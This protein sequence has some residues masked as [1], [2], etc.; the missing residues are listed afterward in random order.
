MRLAF[1]LAIVSLMNAYNLLAQDNSDHVHSSNSSKIVAPCISDMEYAI[2]E[3]R[4]NENRKK[5][6]FEKANIKKTRTTSLS[7][8]LKAANGLNDC[9]Y[10]HISAYVDHNVAV[11]TIQ[12]YNCGT[13]T[14]DGHRGTDISIWPFNFHK[15]DNNQVE[16]IAAAPG[17]ILDKHDGEFDRNC[18]ANNLTANYVIIQHLDGSQILYWHMKKNSIT[19][20]A[21]GQSVVTGEKLG[22]VGSS[23]SSSGPH[24][25]FEVWA[26]NAV[27]TRVDPFSGACNM[28]NA[29]SWWANQKP[30]KET[31]I[32]RA[33]V[34]T[35]DAVIPPC[36]TT[37]TL[38]ES[39]SYT[40]PFQGAGLPPGYAKFYI[41]IKDEINGL[42]GN[43]SILNPDNTTYLSWGYNSV[44]D[45]KIRMW[46]WSKVLPVAPGT[47]TFKA[48]YNGI[49]CSTTFDI[50]L[51]AGIN[52]VD[53]QKQILVYPIPNNG[54]FVVD[55]NSNEVQ[56][57]DILSIDGKLMKHVQLI[58]Q[59]T[60]I[61]LNVSKG[62]YFYQIRNANQVV[63]SGKM[64]VE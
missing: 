44:A 12:D 52:L 36:P 8:P 17:I 61:D 21:I 54:T 51:P 5:I 29:T 7:W 13:I 2:I 28:L 23:G 37:E 24:L 48:E 58:D 34:H 40:I 39:T 50:V 3:N 20:K 33:T 46:G 41:F 56:N 22:V 26:G 31:S 55:K 62:I 4:C 25:H 27:A 15:M 47:Y 18:G 60:S 35:T 45:S 19:A 6:N 63:T 11:G 57:I 42:V 1:I 59:K 30:H 64:I 53:L 14:Y 9:S 49:I 10:Y 32:M 16:V 43:M 38:N